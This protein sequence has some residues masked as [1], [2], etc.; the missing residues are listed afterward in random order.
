[1]SFSLIKKFFLFLIIVALFTGG[2]WQLE[3]FGYLDSIQYG[4]NSVTISMKNN[5]FIGT[6]QEIT[7]KRGE[8]VFI[9]IRNRDEGRNHNLT[10]LDSKIGTTVLKP[11]E[12]E[13]LSFEAKKSGSVP[14]FCTLHATKMKGRLLVKVVE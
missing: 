2:L 4:K 7:M 3:R 1:M 5:K 6:F 9:V 11:G 14:F 13:V 12:K 10:L 8:Q